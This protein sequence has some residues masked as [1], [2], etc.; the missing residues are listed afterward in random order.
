MSIFYF[1]LL[2]LLLY[3]VK[4]APKGQFFEDAFSYE[5]DL[6]LRGFF[7]LLVVFHHMSQ[8]LTHPG[9]LKL[10]WGVGILCVSFFFYL[11]GY[12]LMKSHLLHA[13]YFDS[14]FRRRYS[15]LLLPFF[16][17]NLIYLC[18]NMISGTVYSPTQ[19]IKLLVGLELVNSHAWFI[20][21]IAL[22]DLAF[23]LIFRFGKNRTLQLFILFCF[24]VGYAAF[25][26]QKGA[27]LQLFE[28]SWWFNSSSLFFIGVVM[29]CFEKKLV[30]FL[31]KYYGL[32]CSISVFAF[33]LFYTVSV[34]VINAFPY[35]KEAMSPLAP[36]MAGSW[37]CLGWQSL[38]AIFFCLTVTLFTLKI[39][40]SNP[41][42]RF[43]GKISLELY[44]I[45]GLFIQLFKGQLFTIT[46][47]YLFIFLVLFCS[48]F[49]AYALHR[50]IQALV[51]G[52]RRELGKLPF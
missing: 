31:Q 20:L 50:P 14:Y 22:F 24:Q 11:S 8:L 2:L 47:D 5:S 38:S 6:P 52:T 35:Q 42:L 15:K 46:N 4:T 37:F 16:V 1:L 23:Y 9:S 19:W 7:M 33:L 27:G 48:V 41:I 13:D 40:C 18:I 34:Y 44:L 25:C 49:A 39:K 12:G 43:L 51:Q 17:C 21:T 36:Q 28:G 30:A 32:V 26:M 10:L 29:A 3:H 45:H